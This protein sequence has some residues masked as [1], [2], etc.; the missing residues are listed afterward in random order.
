MGADPAVA[1][2][3]IA[4]AAADHSIGLRNLVGEDAFQFVDQVA[5]AG[6]F[7]VWITVGTGI[8]EGAWLELGWSPLPFTAERR[9]RLRFL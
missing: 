5:Q 8:V 9:P 3:L 7:D 2:A 4:K 1:G 6:T